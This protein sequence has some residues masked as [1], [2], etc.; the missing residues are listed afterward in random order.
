MNGVWDWRWALR[1]LLAAV[2]IGNGLEKFGL[3]W[4]SWL[5]GGTGDVPGMLRMMAEETPIPPVTWLIHG[6]ML[7][8]GNWITV[9]VGILEVIIGV[10][11]GTGMG[12][13]WAGMLGAMIQTFFWAGFLTV[14]WPFQYPLLILAHL[15]L[16]VPAWATDRPWGNSQRWMGLLIACL[17]MLWAYEG[18]TGNWPALLATLLLAGGLIPGLRWGQVSAATGLVLGLTLTALAY[19]AEAWGSFVWAYYAVGAA[20][21]SALWKQAGDRFARHTEN[22]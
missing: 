9:P 16:A 13:R 11:F 22:T 17:T 3:E 21:F 19:R 7:P 4:P 5:L 20:H 12:L 1:A 2:W 6:L 18:R 10:A 14:D 8:L 15:T